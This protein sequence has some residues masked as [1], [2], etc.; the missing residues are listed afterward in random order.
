MPLIKIV[1]SGEERYVS[2]EGEK[3]LSDIL[4]ENGYYIPHPCGGKGSCGKCLVTVNGKAVLSCRHVLAE[5]SVV[6]LPD[7][8]ELTVLGGGDGNG[9]AD[10]GESCLCLDIG[11][12]TLALSLV[13]LKDKAVIRSVTAANPQR[14]FG[15]DVI[16]RIDY[17][18]KHG[19]SAMQ[20]IL[21]HSVKKMISDLLGSDLSRL[22]KM[23]VAGNTTMLHIFFGVDPS[24]IGVSPYTPRFLDEKRCT[25]ADIGISCVGEIVSLP[26]ISSFVGADILA[27][28]CHVG[29]PAEGHYRMLLDLGTNAEIALFSRDTILCTAAA[30]GP[31]FEGANIS[32]GMSASEGAVY[33]VEADGS[34]SIIGDGEP[35]GLCATGLIDAIA[36]GVR[37]GEIDESGYMEEDEMHICGSVNLVPRDVREFQLAKS[38]IRAATECLIRRA[39]IDFSAV[40]GLYVAGGFSA[41]LNV[42]NAV[43]LGLIPE[44]LSECFHGINNSSLMG[45]VK[46]ACYGRGVL[47][48]LE[49]AVYVDLSAD[50]A[51]SELFMEYME[52]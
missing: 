17:C 25:G 42:E 38:A 12:T 34:C 3:L 22:G 10:N 24:S 43:F 19:T 45:T 31:C 37:D 26:G 40:E 5:D 36:R 29:L 52:F 51:F 18:T 48:S 35:R 39:G 33:A 8:E 16:S 23:Y 44:E 49:N 20:T 27:G 30:A 28:I 21:I 2:F 41:S 15:A 4:I 14:T 9:T 50:S 32:C 7:S 47:P 11:T 13:S 46:R 1:R 6:L